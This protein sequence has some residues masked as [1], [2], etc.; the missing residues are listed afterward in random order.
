[1]S[2]TTDTVQ[3]S[4][5]VTLPYLE[6]GDPAGV[7]MVLLHGYSDSSRSFELLLPHLP[8]S[9][10]AYAYT[11]RGHAGA[12]KPRAGY[13]VADNVADAEAFMDA[14]GI[15][16]AMIVGHSAGSYVAQRFALDHPDRTLGVVLIGAF[17]SFHD[18]PGVLEFGEAVAE[19][20]D[21]V[22]PEFVRD[23]QEGCVAEPVPSAFIEAIIAG[24]MELTAQVWK[25]YYHGL[26]EAPVPTES[27]TIAKPVLILW[28]DQD[29]F[30][31]RSDQE[32]LL[33]AIPQAALE[34]YPGTGHCPHWEQPE[35][36]AAEIVAFASDVAKPDLPRPATV[37]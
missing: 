23:F 17:R 27:G 10:H 18:N 30:C 31:P 12:T 6:Q 14:L 22:D 5:G 3:L 21:P 33:A 20:A 2:R 16:A 29:V 36:A 37:I 4:T 11:Q 15:E 34:V 8:D 32:A 35:R 28:G 7:P 24:S 25:D 1:M 13:R 9:I 26:V 19:L